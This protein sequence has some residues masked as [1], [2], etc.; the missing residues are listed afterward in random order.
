MEQ[1]ILKTGKPQVLA[2]PKALYD[3]AGMLIAV[4]STTQSIDLSQDWRNGSVVLHTTNK[5][6]GAPMLSSCAFAYDEANDI[7]YSGFAGRVSSFGNAPNAIPLSLWSFKPDGSGSGTWKEEIDSNDS[8]FNNLLRPFKGYIAYGGDS[9]LVLGG[10]SNFQSDAETMDVEDDIPLPGLLNLKMSTRTFTNS[11]AGGFN[12]KQDAVL[13]RMQYVPSFG[14][15]GLFM[16]MGGS[17]VP[18]DGNNLISFT[19]IWVYDAVTDT[20]F[21]QTATGNVPE[22]RKEFCIAGVNS[23]NGT[24]EIFMYGGESGNLGPDAVPY[25]EIFILTLPAFRWIKVDYPPLHPRH[26]HS[27]N[28]VGGS[29]II[30]IGGVDSNSRIYYGDYFSIGES[31]F[32]SSVDPFAQGLGIFDMTTLTWADH[33][34]ANAPQ[35]VQ[36]DLVKNFYAQNPQNGSQFSSSGLKDLFQTTHFTQAPSS[37]SNPEPTPDPGPGSSSN[38][39]A[40]AGGVVGGIVGLALIAGIAFFILRRRRNRYSKPTGSSTPELQSN[41]VHQL[42]EIGGEQREYYGGVDKNGK[43]YH[44][45]PPL[46]EME[47]A[48]PEMGHDEVGGS[49][50]RPM[51][52]EASPVR[53]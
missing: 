12:R 34:T 21:N 27:C 9:A 22:A 39:G 19:N 14:P 18:D 43:R 4:A 40:I 26:G 10:V 31:T 49:V 16:T 41:N 32:N 52:M 2:P 47:E 53:R 38:T 13:G 23:T 3:V 45:E 48:R 36:S 25:D 30:S 35:Y 42:Q 29:Q 11:S 5:P 51:E 33:Y 20:W 15:N 7:F 37:A 17:R 50:V 24:Y 8:A 1:H 28:A 44:D 46:A 6:S